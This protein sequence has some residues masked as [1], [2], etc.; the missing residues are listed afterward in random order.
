MRAALAFAILP[1]VL[2]IPLQA[3]WK[4]TTVTTD[5]GAR[6]TETEYSSGQR[7]RRDSKDG[8]VIIDFAASRQIAWSV[9]SREYV[10]HR[11]KPDKHPET[12]GPVIVFH[13]DTK[14][15]GERRTMFGRNARHL[16]TREWRESAPGEGSV[17]D[18]WYV[19]V[20][21]LPPMK[22]GVGVA[23]LTAGAAR[24]AV[25]IKRTGAA[26]RGLAVLETKTG[27]AGAFTRHVTDLYEGPLDPAL[28]SPPPGYRL[29]PRSWLEQFEDLLAGLFH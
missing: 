29:G 12:T 22:N 2:A 28:F 23:V 7:Y 3:G 9:P 5:G 25:D 20:D 13:L 1:L 26:I 15:T 8:G 10:V 4:I 11:I 27:A 14:D 18:A 6:F 17:T 19:D 24:P 21:S 16:I